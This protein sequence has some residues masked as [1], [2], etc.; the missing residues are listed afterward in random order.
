MKYFFVLGSNPAL[1]LAEIN[2]VINLKEAKLL[3]PDLLVI[4]S[5]TEI[6]PS[7]LITRLGGVIK[8]GVI[9]EELP[10]NTKQAELV[11]QVC[12]IAQAKQEIVSEGKFNFGFSDYGSYQFNKQDLGIKLKNYF[13]AKNISSRFVISREKNLS[14]VIVEQNKLLKRGIE[15]ILAKDENN[16]FLGETLAVQPF[17]DLS[18]RDYG[19]PARDDQSGMLPPKLAQAMIN[20]A[21]VKNTSDLILDPFCGS[22]TILSEAMLLGFKN[23]F[24]LDI[25]I[26]AIE[27]TKK[28]I[29]W[30][31]ELYQ[32]TDVKMKF[33]VKNVLHLN[34]FIKN[35]SAAAIITEPY[36][37]PQRGKIDFVEITRE[38]EEL[39]SKAIEQCAQ[40]LQPGSRLVMVW[41]IF[42]GDRPINPK[43]HSSLKE[44]K[45]LPDTFINNLGLK[46]FLN[47]R[48]NIVYGRTG[49]KVFREII[50]L[51]KAL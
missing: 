14:S 25:S 44:V 38:L 11:L 19:R 13:K 20:L 5:E 26:Q 50:V 31:K 42:Y 12:Q 15:I 7:S 3:A 4:S 34:K 30:T 33:L 27:N 41:P 21:Q 24:G 1:S 47:V 22:G 49:Q 43:I 8:I 23:I 35:N 39:Y 36:L 6:N 9:K 45:I 2:A 18:R 32:L 10:I 17:K 29:S 40:V 46:K 51:E 28:N 37:G 16:V 48:G